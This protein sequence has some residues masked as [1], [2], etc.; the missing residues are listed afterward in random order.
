MIYLAVIIGA[1]AFFLVA[2]Y[3]V[4]HS[5]GY[6]GLGRVVATLMAGAGVAVDQLTTLPWDK[7]LDAGKVIA[8]T[9]GLLIGHIVVQIYTVVT[10]QTTPPAPPAA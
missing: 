9:T 2:Y 6:T 3:I 1:L 8:V 10:S 4:H 7:L 5:M